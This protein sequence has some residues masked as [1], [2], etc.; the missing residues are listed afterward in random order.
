MD[1]AIIAAVIAGIVTVIG[2]L[3]TS[4]GKRDE[5][6]AA[7]SSGLLESMERRLQGYEARL[8]RAEK[9]IDALKAD[10]WRFQAHTVALRRALS[11]ALEWIADAVE[12]MN[13][14]RASEPPTP[15]D[16]GAWHELIR[17]VSEDLGE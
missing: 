11:K 14:D 5:V 4:I 16:S 8:D 9:Q 17:G 1:S 15:P 6:A 13:G 10:L 3:L 2:Y 7:R 12:W